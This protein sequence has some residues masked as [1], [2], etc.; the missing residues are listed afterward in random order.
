M[1]MIAKSLRLVLIGGFLMATAFGIAAPFLLHFVYGGKFDGAAFPLRILLP[2]VVLVSGTEVLHSGLQSIN[3][4]SYA[5]WA[6]LAGFFVTVIGL[7][8]SLRTF[9]IVGAAVTSTASYLACFITAL[10]LLARTKQ[11]DVVQTISSRAF[12][13]DVALYCARMRSMLAGAS[14]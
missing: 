8:L 13:A 1:A 10:V 4:G 12:A 14:K 5:S 3:K 6:Q 9:G 11:I 2:G 7:E